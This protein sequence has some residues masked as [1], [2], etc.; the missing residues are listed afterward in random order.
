MSEFI[1]MLERMVQKLDQA[2]D[3]NKEM[4]NKTNNFP[5]SLQKTSLLNFLM[6]TDMTHS[7]FRVSCE[8][9]ILIQKDLDRIFQNQNIIHSE[10]TKINPNIRLLS[11]NSDDNK[12]TIAILNDKVDRIKHN[13]KSLIK[14]YK[15]SEGKNKSNYT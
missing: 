7:S 2:I 12:K 6:S 1:S 11:K 10:L 8:F 9:F 14:E 13:V 4:T 5:D 15:K 3:E